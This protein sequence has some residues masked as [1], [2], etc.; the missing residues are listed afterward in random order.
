MEIKPVQIQSLSF[1]IPQRI[2][3]GVQVACLLSFVLPAFAAADS[4]DLLTVRESKYVEMQQTQKV[5]GSVSDDF[6]PLVGVSIHVK[7]TTNGTVTDMDG[8]FSLEA[9]PGDILVISYVGYL[10]IEHK[11]TAGP[12]NL[13]MKE[14][15]QKLDEVIVLGYGTT[16]KRSM[17]AAVSTVN[18]EEMAALPVTNITQGLAGRS[19]GLIVQGSGGGINKTSTVSIRGGGTPLVVIDGVIR[20]YGDFVALAPENIANLSILKDASAT[21]VYGSRASNGILQVTTKQGKEGKPQI[22]Y[23]FNQSWSQPNVWPD[24]LNS[25]ERAIHRNVAAA[26]DGVTIPYN[27]DDLRMFADGSDP[28]GH[29]NTDWQK[30]V[31]KNFAPQQKHNITISGGGASNTYYA[32]IGHINQQSLYKSDSHYMKRTNFQLT[33]TSTFKS[34]GLKT[35][36]QLDGYMQF[37]THPYTSTSS[38]YGNVFS[39]VQNKSPMEIGRNKYGLV[40]NNTDNP[41]AE[42]SDDGGYIDEKEN[43]VNGLLGVEWDLPWVKGLK[44]RAKGSY[45]YYIK[46]NKSW[47]KDAAQ[48]AWDSQE[49]TYASKPQLSQYG[50]LGNSWTLQYFVEYNRTFG[51]HSVSALGGYEYTS[52]FGHSMGLVRKNYDFPIDQINPGPSSTMENSGG[53]WEN[54]RAGW[55]GQVKY[56]YD[57]RYFVEAS[58]RYDGSDN[59]PKDHRWGTFYSGSIGWSLADE[60]FM[61]TIREKHIF[62]MLKIRASYGQVGLDNWGNDG[63]TYHIGRFA[64]LTSYGLG[65]Q[66]YV[67]NGEYVPGFWEGSLPSPDLTW[68]TTDQFDAG[69]DFS[70][71]NNRL[72]GSFDYFYYATKGFLYAPDALDVG[73]T[74]PLGV[75]LPK[76]S[77]DG[78]H[79]RAGVEFQLGWRDDIG[80]FHYDVAFNFTKFDELWANNPSESLE[81]KKNPYKRTT[82]QRGYAGVYY[83]NMGF[84]K[85]AND[86]Y[87]SVQRTGSHSLTA[88]DLKYYDFNG[89]GVID[90]ADQH[91]LGKSSF[92]RANYGL[93]INLS[94]KGFSFSTLFQ[95]ATRFDMYLGSVLMMSD[96]N[97]GSSPTYE[98][99]TDYWT[100]ENTDAKFPRLLS[101]TGNNGSN[102]TVGSD[103]WL[104]NGGYLRMR[105]IQVGYDFKRILLKKTSW[106]TRLNVALSG[107]NIF[108]ISEATKYGIDPENG[109]ANRYDYP[110]E[111]VFAINFGIGF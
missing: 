85:D 107:Q 111:R 17:I 100:P 105:D 102:N 31:M 13:S 20:D 82:Q 78:E 54:G 41:I 12:V 63:D 97:T 43:V 21:A 36:A 18:A 44:L 6:G 19:P 9:K 8:N 68:F 33:Q 22:D 58:M 81:N 51:K 25:Y 27:D 10:T 67:M 46:D 66:E 76:I 55:V 49:P 37:K 99:Q 5:S 91:R 72:Y 110:N 4:N 75:S 87:N 42:I 47:R 15:T 104:I 92:P 64:Y 93:N 52:G 35:T 28:Y 3:K 98:F 53:E 69:F 57:N 14:D 95:G 103:F 80:D 50:E 77:T 24:K 34:I 74:D 89:D 56:N 38:G 71:L 61:E 65:G 86:V 109:S 11:V 45:R 1:S 96:A 26:N 59:F 90:G 106:I 79:R 7:G 73:Y 40:Y 83:E 70:S 23:N 108:T 94:Y 16:T 29:P 48:Y 101:S 62:D 88:G 2:V 30:E 32:S 39:H 84:Y 60:A